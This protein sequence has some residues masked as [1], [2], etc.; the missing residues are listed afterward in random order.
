MLVTIEKYERWS[1]MQRLNFLFD[2]QNLDGT[3]Q[4]LVKHSSTYFPFTLN[5]SSFYT[6]ILWSLTGTN[7]IAF[8]T[9]YLLFQNSQYPLLISF[10]L[11]CLTVLFGCNSLKLK[12]SIHI[13]TSTSKTPNYLDFG[14]ERFQK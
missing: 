9:L 7:T 11:F 12:N 5:N 14:C 6:Y 8:L 1:N 3:L 4:Q 10:T 13:P 2:V